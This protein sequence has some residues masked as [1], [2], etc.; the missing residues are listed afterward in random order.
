MF[1]GLL[2]PHGN[3]TPQRSPGLSLVIHNI[4]VDV[5]DGRNGEHRLKIPKSLNDL[6][7]YSGA[8]TAFPPM[9][10]A[11]PGDPLPGQLLLAAFLT[12]SVHNVP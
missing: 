3:T 9:Q 1:L 12:A 8:P 10:E 6:Q 7:A 5:E 4:L 11:A 2:R